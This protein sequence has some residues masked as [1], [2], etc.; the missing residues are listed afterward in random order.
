M[1]CSNW[2]ALRSNK[3]VFVAEYAGVPVL[4]ST[5]TQR[6]VNVPDPSKLRNWTVA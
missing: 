2:S 5:R 1:T 4:D 6:P 3:N